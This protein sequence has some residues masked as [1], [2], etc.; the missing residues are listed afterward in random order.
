MS[1]DELNTEVLKLILEY[2]QKEK[3]DTKNTEYIREWSEWYLDLVGLAY[4]SVILDKKFNPR[5]AWRITDG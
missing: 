2:M 4:R 1:K 3:D 5:E